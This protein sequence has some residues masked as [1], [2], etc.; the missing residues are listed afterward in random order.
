M[1]EDLQRSGSVVA[2]PRGGATVIP[3]RDGPYLLRGDFRIVDQNGTEV[4]LA[5]RTVA[6]CRCGRSRTRPFCDGTHRLAGFR[7]SGLAEDYVPPRAVRDAQERPSDHAEGGDRRGEELLERVAALL[8][9]AHEAVRPAR[10]VACPAPDRPVLRRVEPLL[11][12]A[13]ALVETRALVP[14]DPHPSTPRR[15]SREDAARA[16]EVALIAAMS[17]CEQ[18]PDPILETAAALLGDAAEI[19]RVPG[20]RS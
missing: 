12:S 6:L 5:R 7:A 20:G 1:G 13:C 14:P 16:V 4:P 11:R 19:L 3:Y 18:G 2:S 17:A 15:C 8:K 10:G 9:D